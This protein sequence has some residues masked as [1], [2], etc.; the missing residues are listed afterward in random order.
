M[1]SKTLKLAGQFRGKNIWLETDDEHEVEIIGEYFISLFT[2]NI[3]L[4]TEKE[5][6]EF[7]QYKK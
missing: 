7:N 4:Q 2:R 3:T 5:I 1:K 6:Q